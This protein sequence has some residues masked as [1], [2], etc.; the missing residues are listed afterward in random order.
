MTIAALHKALID[1][2]LERHGKFRPL[3]DVAAVTQFRLTLRKQR[4]GGRRFVYRVT[5]STGN[6]I[7][8]V[9]RGMDICPVETIRMA[10][11][12]SVERLFRTKL[13]EGNDGGLSSMRLNVRLRW[14]MAALAT[15]VGRFFFS[16][17]N[18]LEMRIL[19]ELEPH[20]GM[21]GFAGIAA[22]VSIFL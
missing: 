21:A 18:T 3:G 1:A 11:K 19:V 12:A 8:R 20:V 5:V 22:H 17:G 14:T 15:R 4:F 16:N 6:V 13:S 2:M 7:P 9:L 10:A